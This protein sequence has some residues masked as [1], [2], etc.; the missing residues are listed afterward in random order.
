MEAAR[1]ENTRRAKNMKVLRN[2][3]SEQ[4]AQLG[5]Q[6]YVLD[7]IAART[8]AAILASLQE[9]HSGSVSSATSNDT[10]VHNISDPR[11][12][13]E[14]EEVDEETA[15][16]QDLLLSSQELSGQHYYLCLT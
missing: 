14:E 9:L 16:I 5:R 13:E 10:S 11:G 1:K 12:E 3:S 2:H 8:Q 4:Y 6:K 7:R 15:T